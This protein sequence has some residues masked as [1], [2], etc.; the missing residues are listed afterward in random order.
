MFLRFSA[1]QEV[2]TTINT[3]RNKQK[4]SVEWFNLSANL[5]LSAF[6]SRTHNWAARISPRWWLPDL[7]FW[8]TLDENFMGLESSLEVE[9]SVNNLPFWTSTLTNHLFWLDLPKKHTDKNYNFC[10][11]H[12]LTLLKHFNF[13]DCFKTFFSFQNIKTK[14]F[15]SWF[16]QKKHKTK[17]SIFF[18]KNHGLTPLKKKRLLTGMTN[19][20]FEENHWL[21][22]WPKVVHKN[23]LHPHSQ[24]STSISLH[25]PS[26]FFIYLQQL[27]F[28]IVYLQSTLFTFIYPQ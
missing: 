3:N 15:L 10:L 28:T 25:S 1:A 17:I 12:G 4:R 21:R 26:F 18:Y 22:Q 9:I 19:S 16:A 23:P 14:S 7:E 6:P 27:S 5:R 20:R 8:A 24:M 11:N 13:L 2:M